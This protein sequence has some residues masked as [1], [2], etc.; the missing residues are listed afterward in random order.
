MPL[1]Y[2]DGVT[3]APQVLPS[4]VNHFKS[5][6]TCRQI[7]IPA[8]QYRIANVMTF[9]RANRD[10]LKIQI[11]Q[12]ILGLYTNAVLH[13]L[14]E[15]FVR[16]Q[17]R[18]RGSRRV[19]VP[20]L[21]GVQRQC[22]RPEFGGIEPLDGKRGFVGQCRGGMPRLDLMTENETDSGMVFLKSWK[23]ALKE[24]SMDLL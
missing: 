11:H 9:R 13:Q 8:K 18:F 14:G 21:I 20:R 24:G 5:S 17:T 15:T 12:H 2:T 22:E 19:I 23:D 4:L 16:F 3:W 6:V 1:T 10:R 7:P